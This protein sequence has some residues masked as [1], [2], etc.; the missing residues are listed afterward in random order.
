MESALR[1]ANTAAALSITRLGAQ[2]SLPMRAEVEAA[3]A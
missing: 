1:F 2:A 3:Y